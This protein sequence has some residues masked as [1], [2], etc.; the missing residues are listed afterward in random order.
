MSELRRERERERECYLGSQ[1]ALVII[2]RE[3]GLWRWRWGEGWGSA[4]DK[5]SRVLYNWWET[6]Y[7]TDIWF[8]SV[9]CG[10]RRSGRPDLLR[11]YT[12]NT[13]IS[14]LDI[15]PVQYEQ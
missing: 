13:H 10:W 12:A 4:I 9:Y 6:N 1:Q 2:I 7:K 14:R 5:S 3:E 8:Y 11:G 15:Y